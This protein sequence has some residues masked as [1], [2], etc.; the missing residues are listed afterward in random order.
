MFD[1]NALF[2]TIGWF[3]VYVSQ[4]GSTVLFSLV[5]SIECHYNVPI[6]VSACVATALHIA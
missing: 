6:S 4:T 2:K 5:V 3:M 1:K